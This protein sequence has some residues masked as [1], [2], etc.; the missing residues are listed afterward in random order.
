MKTPAG[1][2]VALILLLLIGILLLAPMRAGNDDYITVNV[3]GLR[4]NVGDSYDIDYVLYSEKPQSVA[5]VSAD[6]AIATVDSVGVVTAQAPGN[7]HIRLIAQNG[8]RT[9]VSIEVLGG[10]AQSTMT[11]SADRIDLERGQISGLKAIFSDD[12]VDNRVAWYSEDESVATVDAVG[13]ISA[14]GGG[15][16][17]IVA[18]SASGLTASAQVSVY[19]PGTA[20][21]IIPADVTVGV[22]ATLKMDCYYLPDG[23]TDTIARWQSSN[24]D[25]LTVNA[26]GVIN[27]RGVGQVVLSV[28]SNG[29]LSGST[30]VHVEPSASDFELSPSAVTIERDHTIDLA[31]RF[32][33][34]RGN[35]ATG[36]ES[37]YV[38]WSA[39]NPDI[40]S[41]DENGKVTGHRS[42]MSRITAQCDGMTAT[43]MVTVEVVVREI[44]LNYTEI[45]LSR[46]ETVTPI[47]LMATLTPSDPDDDGLTF[48]TNN[49]QVAYV[50]SNGLITMTG[51]YGT[52]I[53]TATAS[54]GASATCTLTVS[55]SE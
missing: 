29:G 53:I 55:V 51:A 43:C 34:D 36:Y 5:Y 44:A 17:R 11:L 28:F 22:G 23:A 10:T 30:F 15:E 20:M 41:V 47:Q 9:Q 18:T 50:D 40:A 16:T 46:E 35:V 25:M 54:S 21:H 7:T 14:V 2:L 48:E 52:A 26:D 8:A 33:D 1:R 6:T 27:A 32:L 13:R 12:S 42:G 39:S 19:V 45:H 31:T 3:R 38:T 37:H 24:E 4:M 49:P